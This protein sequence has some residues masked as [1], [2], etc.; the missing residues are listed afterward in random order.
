M[1]YLGIDY[2]HKRIGLALSDDSGALARPLHIVE[3]KNALE[4]IANTIEENNVDLI[5]IG[6]SVNN[7][8]IHNPIHTEAKQFVELLSTQTDTPFVFMKEFFSSVVARGN[9]GKESLHAHKVKKPEQVHADAKA[10]AVILQR[11][12][13][14]LPK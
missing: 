10:A 13:D 7:I 6:E 5:V 8:G 14:S 1:K 11:Y 3:S 4:N 12:I 9:V 2:G